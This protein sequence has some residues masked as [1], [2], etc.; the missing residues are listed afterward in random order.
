MDPKDYWWYCDLRKYGSCRH[1]GYGLG[2]ERDGHVP[3]RHLQH[4]GR[5]AAPENVGQRRIL[6]KNKKAPDVEAAC[7]QLHVGGPIA[8]GGGATS[9]VQAFCRR[10]NLAAD[11]I[12]FR[13]RFSNRVPTGAG[14][15][16]GRSCNPRTWGNAE[17]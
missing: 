4:P 8:D 15:G 10:Q 16:C 9:A 14:R 6:K 3:H 5:G 2:F 12:H 11:G 1:A 13:P 17:F 7:P